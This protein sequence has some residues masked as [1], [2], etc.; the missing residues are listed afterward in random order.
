MFD[1]MAAI[2]MPFMLDPTAKKSRVNMKMLM[3]TMMMTMTSIKLFK[4][5]S[6][7]KGMT[8]QVRQITISRDKQRYRD[9]DV[10]I[11]PII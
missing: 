3:K 6:L 11:R 8:R 10:V 9:R 5:A 4:T 1:N 7:Y 2:T